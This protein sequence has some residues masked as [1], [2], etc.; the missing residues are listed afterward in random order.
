MTHS[1]RWPCVLLPV[2]LMVSFSTGC[3]KL[4]AAGA[5]AA[6]EQGT[7]DDGGSWN[8]TPVTQQVLADL[9]PS[10]PAGGGSRGSTAPAPAPRPAPWVDPT[11]TWPDRS[12]DAWLR[13]ASIPRP[14]VQPEPPRAS[15]G[16]KGKPPTRPS[17]S[18]QPPSGPAR[19]DRSP[20]PQSRASAGSGSP[21][22]SQSAGVGTSSS[23]RASQSAGV[24]A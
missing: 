12:F 17:S 24:G 7:T 4:P 6:L 19:N 3:A 21:G 9:T 5:G 22:A 16:S 10:R 11:T 2:V 14:A 15:P 1:T 18:N 8:V 20:A 23:Q 13:G